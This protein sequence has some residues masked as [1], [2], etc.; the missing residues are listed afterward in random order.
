MKKKR[1][2]LYLLFRKKLPNVDNNPN[3]E[4]SPNLVTLSATLFLLEHMRVLCERQA[5]T[6]GRFLNRF[7]VLQ[8]LKKL[9]CFKDKQKILRI[10]TV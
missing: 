2:S 7:A 6:F 5:W 8:K 4:N 9:G 3:G 1:K 10:E